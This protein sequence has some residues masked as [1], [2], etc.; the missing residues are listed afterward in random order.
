MSRKEIVFLILNI[1][2]CFAL[3]F[4]FTLILSIIKKGE[5]YGMVGVGIILLSFAILTALIDLLVLKLLKALTAA[6]VLLTIFE[7]FIFY[8][9]MWYLATNTV[10]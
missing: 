3:L 9:F 10:F 6:T 2:A 8:A 4:L 1:P 7:V 5:A